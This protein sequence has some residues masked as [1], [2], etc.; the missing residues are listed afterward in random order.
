[1]KQEDLSNDKFKG[2]YVKVQNGNVER[3]LSIFKRKVKDSGLM[4]ELKRRQQYE[5]PSD[6]RRQK[7]NLANLREKSQKMQENNL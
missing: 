2:L 4:L 7:R 5:K 6:L 1:M 3:A